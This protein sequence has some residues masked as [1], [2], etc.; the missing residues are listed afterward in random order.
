MIDFLQAL[1]AFAG[2][3]SFIFIVWEK[4][5]RQH[6]T[7]IFVS[8]PLITGGA[9]K[10]LSL[11]ITNN[12]TRPL[13][14]TFE[15]G[16]QSTNLSVSADNTLSA[17]AQSIAFEAIS[18]ALDAGETR[19]LPVYHP[20]NFDELE[21]DSVMEL[22]FHWQLAQPIVWQRE[23]RTTIRITKRASQIMTDD[24]TNVGEGF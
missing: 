16:L 2:F 13:I 3:A 14:V 18:I 7:A 20:E 4:W 9:N 11:R 23:R 24:W 21:A 12:A 17:I 10:S 8:Q 22:P 5:L 15:N 1:G 19:L 6:P